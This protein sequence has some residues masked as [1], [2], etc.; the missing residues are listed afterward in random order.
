MHRSSPVIL[1]YEAKLGDSL[2][3][4]RDSWEL[5]G[6]LKGAGNKR[7]TKE[8]NTLRICD[9]SRVPDVRGRNEEE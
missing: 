8:G 5:N 3:L 4:G 6:E 7:E 1:S 2:S 9:V